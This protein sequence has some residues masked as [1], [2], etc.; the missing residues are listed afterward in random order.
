M[1]FSSIW[2]ITQMGFEGFETFEVL[3]KTKLK[4]VPEKPGVYMVI[5]DKPDSPVFLHKSRA[6]LYKGSDPSLPISELK[7]AWVVN[8]LVLY[9]GKAGGTD[10]SQT[11]R[12]R[13]SKYVRTG[14]RKNSARWGGR[15]IWQL[16][17]STTFQVC[18][19]CTS[20]Q[21]PEDAEGEL[22]R[23]FIEKYGKKPFANR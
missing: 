19:K 20:A 4:N 2:S 15:L 16:V 22:L 1:E 10:I 8:A 18:W 17:E 6:G 12:K 11:L 14:Y 7:R 9:I 5:R 3:Q 21:E 23:N 13:L